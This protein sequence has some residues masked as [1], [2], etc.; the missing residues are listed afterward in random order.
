MSSDISAT[1]PTLTVIG[2][3]RDIPAFRKTVDA[4]I[5]GEPDCILLV[6]FAGE[7][8]QVPRLEQNLALCGAGMRRIQLVDVAAKHRVDHRGCRK[9]G[10]RSTRN[11][12]PVALPEPA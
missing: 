6:E 7:E 1:Q 11:E 2:L 4:F 3:A 12:P 5:K 8:S 9:V 10:D